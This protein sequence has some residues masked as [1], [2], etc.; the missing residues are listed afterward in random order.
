MCLRAPFPLCATAHAALAAHRHDPRLRARRR[1][2][3]W[4]DDG[5][6]DRQCAGGDGRGGGACERRQQPWPR[7]RCSA[8]AGT[9]DAP[10]PWKLISDQAKPVESMLHTC[11]CW[12]LSFRT[13]TPTCVST[14]PC[15]C[16]HVRQTQSCEFAWSASIPHTCK[17]PVTPAV[18]GRPRSVFALREPLCRFILQSPVSRSLSIS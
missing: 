17:Q 11:M 10:H 2:R 14:T 15:T 12:Q 8:A 9:Q 16:R 18:G 1:R 4:R 7:A 3:Q 13:H 5:H 6:G